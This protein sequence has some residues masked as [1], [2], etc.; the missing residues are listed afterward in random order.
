MVEYDYGMLWPLYKSYK[1]DVKTPDQ[2]SWQGVLTGE[3][4]RGTD[5]QLAEKS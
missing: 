5:I 4:F 3:K 1:W 2:L